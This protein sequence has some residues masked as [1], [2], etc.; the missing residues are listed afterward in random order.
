MRITH[1]IWA[2]PIGGTET[3]L[4]EVVNRQCLK[5]KITLIIINNLFN[6]D[7][8]NQIHK[9]VRIIKIN[10]PAGSKNPLYILKL[11][12]SVL[13]SKAHIIHCHNESISALIPGFKKRTCLTVH[14]VSFIPKYLKNFNRIFAISKS[15]KDYI[16][17]EAGINATLIY[18]GIDSQSI[19]VKQNYNFNCFKILQVS[20][21]DHQIK[22]QDL[23]INALKYLIS[24]LGI[25]DVQLDFIGAGPSLEYLKSLVAS[26]LI[27]KYVK[28][29]GE[30]GKLSV[31]NTICDY[32]LLVQP[33][34]C[35]GFGLTIVE[36]MAAKVPILVSNVDGLI[37]LVQNGLFGSYFKSDD[38]MDCA[39]KIRDIILNYSDYSLASR[40]N[41]TREYAISAFDISS[42]VEHYLNE[43]KNR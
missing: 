36:G 14:A 12:L 28:F 40:L 32:N 37:E 43:Y 42:T 26:N 31:Y 38:Y 41:K 19:K 39:I 24:D 3:M 21:L 16:F 33:S 25:R 6:I 4:V 30:M 22:G 2:F 7:L 20:R 29:R 11:W 18:N 23:L 1:V 10:R 17:R 34:I 13:F 9:N 5:A 8:I 35:E 15:V 27:E